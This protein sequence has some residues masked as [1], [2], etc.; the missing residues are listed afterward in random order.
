MEPAQQTYDS[1]PSRGWWHLGQ[2]M[3]VSSGSGEAARPLVAA[4]FWPGTGG[5]KAAA[6]SGVMGHLA[7]PPCSQV[8]MPRAARRPAPMAR[9]TVAPPVTMSPPAKTPGRLVDWVASS[10]AM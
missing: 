7:L 2:S 6:S 5:T 10:A 8:A 4:G 9:I 3:T 1:S